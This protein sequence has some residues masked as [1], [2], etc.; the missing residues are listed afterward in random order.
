MEKLVKFFCDY[1]FIIA[2]V[3]FMLG[4][5]I[6]RIWWWYIH[7]IDE[8]EPK[9]YITDKDGNVIEIKEE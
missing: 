6:S 2:P 8:E 4:L 7:I 3:L 5:V 1:Y 9:V